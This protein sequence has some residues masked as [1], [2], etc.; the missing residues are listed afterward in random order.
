P[1]ANLQKGSRPFVRYAGRRLQASIKYRAKNFARHNRRPELASR[2]TI[3]PDR[4]SRAASFAE[5]LSAKTEQAA[6][7]RKT[8]AASANRVPASLD[9]FPGMPRSVRPRR[10]TA[11]L[12]HGCPDSSDRSVRE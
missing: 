4:P 10:Y 7:Y 1:K 8:Q 9:A 3:L 12:R 5:G 2:L 6:D 11:A